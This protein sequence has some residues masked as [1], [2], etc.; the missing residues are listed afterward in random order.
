MISDEPNLEYEWIEFDLG[1]VRL[2]LG[3]VTLGRADYDQWVTG[4]MLQY[5][6]RLDDG[7]TTVKNILGGDMVSAIKISLVQYY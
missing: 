1:E 3:A 5:T 6:D 4:V 2:V 7:W